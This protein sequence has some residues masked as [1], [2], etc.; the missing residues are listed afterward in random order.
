MVT[1]DEF[2]RE[3]A[4]RNYKPLTKQ[5][6]KVLNESPEAK[7]TGIKVVSRGKDS[8]KTFITY[9][10]VLIIIGIAVF[11]YLVYDGRLSPVTDL[12]CGNVTIP[13]CPSNPVSNECGDCI[14]NCT[15]PSII[16]I[17][18]QNTSE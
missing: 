5:E 14:L 7:G 13:S 2:K 18:Y 15:M 17:K 16:T 3:L 6:F 8:F 11:L 10:L 1:I 9:I 12:V 4:E